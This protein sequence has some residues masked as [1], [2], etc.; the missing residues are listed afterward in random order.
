MAFDVSARPSDVVPG[1]A[2]Q[3][4]DLAGRARADGVRFLMALFVD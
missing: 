4:S 1:Q 3:F 2:P